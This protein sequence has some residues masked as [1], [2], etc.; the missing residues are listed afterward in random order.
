[1]T[2]IQLPVGR[3]AGFRGRVGGGLRAGGRISTLQVNVGYV[4]NLAC[5][6]CHVE[7][8][9][10]RTAPGD[11]MDEATA[12]RVVGWAVAQPEITTVD[13]TGGS[14]EMNPN[15]RWMVQTLHGR[16]LYVIDRCNPT[17][18][19]HADPHTGEPYAWIPE[20]LAAHRV[21][22]VASMPCYL[23]ANVDGQRGRGSFEASIEGLRRLVAVGYGT[24]PGLPLNLVYNPVGP[25]L[26]PPQEALAE[27]YRRELHG[28]YG[29]AFTEL[30]TI[31]NM[32]IRRWRRELEREGTLDDYMA[33]L[34]DAFN[35]AT[36]DGLM[37]RHQISVD[38]QGRLYDC[39]FNQA[40]GLR[41]SDRQSALLWELTARDL[42]GRAIA[43]DD[44]CY[45]CTAG[46]GSSCGGAI[47]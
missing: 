46:C 29:I 23:Q 34:V 1:V 26:P 24:D 31:T 18:I 3:G 35:P 16:G 44:H 28:R 12:R 20:F 17:V 4:C 43:T 40:L 45:G 13:F 33:L 21:E 42:A 32:P 38:P 6:H 11:N 22:V 8:S 5:R 14:P 39:D 25:Q 10:A 36:L 9:P 47:V 19:G 37:C 27:D 30:W 7:S 15:F 41:T 2:G